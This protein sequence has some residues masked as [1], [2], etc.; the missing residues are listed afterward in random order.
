MLVLLLFFG[1]MKRL[2]RSIV[3]IRSSWLVLLRRAGLTSA[4]SA[5]LTRLLAGVLLLL[6]PGFLLAF[7][8]QRRPKAICTGLV[9]FSGDLD[10]GGLFTCFS[11][12]LTCCGAAGLLLGLELGLN[13]SNKLLQDRTSVLLFSSCVLQ[14]C[15]PKVCIKGP[16]QMDQRI[17]RCVCLDWVAVPALYW[18]KMQS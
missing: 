2:M 18:S 11:A 15:R 13:R 1:L 5:V 4:P 14:T 6:L 16:Q 3:L 9:C 17:N 12:D 10:L 7:S 8:G